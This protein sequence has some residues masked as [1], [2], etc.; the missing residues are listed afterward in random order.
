MSAVLSGLRPIPVR[1]RSNC[2][3]AATLPRV[4]A[5]PGLAEPYHLAASSPHGRT[6]PNGGEGASHRCP[7]RDLAAR[8]HGSAPHFTQLHGGK[9]HEGRSAAHR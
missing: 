1:S 8:M 2:P 4:A 7:G 3:R 9:H 5:G 6:S